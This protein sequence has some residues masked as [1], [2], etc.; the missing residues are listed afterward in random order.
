MELGTIYRR[1][2]SLPAENVT[3]IVLLSIDDREARYKIV[4]SWNEN[5]VGSEHT[6]G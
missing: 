2:N 1:R 3:K 4:A 6:V 5:L